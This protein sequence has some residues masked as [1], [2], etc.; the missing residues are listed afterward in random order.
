MINLFINQ[1]SPGKIGNL[2][3]DATLREQ[4]TYRNDVTIFPVEEG[5][6]VS[7]HVQPQHPRLVISGLVSN[8][9]LLDV[10]NL[11][12]SAVDTFSSS[13]LGRALLNTGTRTEMALTELMKLTGWEYPTRTV[14]SSYT[15]REVVPVTV[16]T[17]LRVYT[18]MVMT[19]LTIDRDATTGD[20][21]PFTVE[22]THIRRVRFSQTL[23]P[24]VPAADSVSKRTS[25]T[26]NV[27]K[28]TAAEE[29]TQKTSILA[30]IFNKLSGGR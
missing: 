6:N 14:S 4:H 27:G 15:P 8:T 30:G 20:S 21:L 5:A 12:T 23:I 24:S 3:L 1:K 26:S 10:G 29:A 16:V 11:V 13:P 7:D 28:V 18:D 25:P 9:P 19:S 17:G 22:F 2:T